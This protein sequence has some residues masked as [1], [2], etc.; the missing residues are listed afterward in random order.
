MD[1]DI[2]G[3]LHQIP[4]PPFTT[5]IVETWLWCVEEGELGGVPLAPSLWVA[6]IRVVASEHKDVGEVK[7]K[8]RHILPRGRNCVA[9]LEK[10]GRPLS[11][12]MLE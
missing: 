7:E 5:Q 6:A 3:G 8:K 4:G 11:I 1:S 2:E 10:G 9:G 12:A